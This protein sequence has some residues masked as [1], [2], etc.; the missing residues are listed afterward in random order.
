MA[1]PIGQINETI[2]NTVDTV[3]SVRRNVRTGV[4]DSVK[5]LLPGD[6]VASIVDTVV[7]TDEL[8]STNVSNAIK[9]ASTAIAGLLGDPGKAQS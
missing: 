4:A 6:P 7:N 3:Q 9:Q 5:G 2:H 1:N 8:L